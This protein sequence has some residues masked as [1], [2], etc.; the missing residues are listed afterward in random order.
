[1]AS[2]ETPHRDPL[3]GLSGYEDFLKAFDEEILKAEQEGAPIS[4]ALVD[5]DNMKAINDEY[6]HEIG[7]LALKWVAKHLQDI[8]SAS[9]IVFRYRIDEP[10]EE[11]KPAS[12][13]RKRWSPKPATIQEGNWKIWP[14]S[15]NA[16]E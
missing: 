2:Q 15:P 3:T 13:D 1:M 5:I 4:L 8:A 10:Q 12:Q 11:A 16:K 7:D 14:N 9:G 6:G